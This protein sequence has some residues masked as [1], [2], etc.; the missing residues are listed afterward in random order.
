MILE[1]YLRA[2]TPEECIGYLAE[3]GGEARLLAGGTDLIPRMAQGRLSVRALIDLA[4]IPELNRIESGDGGVLIGAMRRL[5][6]VQKEGLLSGPLDV[7]RQCAG[8][9]SSM[10][11]RNA[12]T[13]GG[14]VCNASPAADT[15]PGLLVL[16]AVA[17]TYGRQGPGE[18]PLE[19]FFT[20]P[21][22]TVLQPGELLIG[23]RIPH[24][25]LHTGAAYRKYAIR[26]DSDIS[27]VGAGA[28]LTLDKQGRIAEARIAL[29]SAGPAP[30]RM[31]GEEKMLAGLLPEA[32]AFKEAAESCAENCS[33][34]TD[35]RA[36]KEYRKEMIRLWVEDALQAAWKAIAVQP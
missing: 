8:H 25:P 10:Q 17:L 5:G 23:L 3:Y 11:I 35:H 16:D 9:V 14:N 22:R 27:I 24:P 20:G 15:V 26:G 32:K 6:A 4:R 7:L 29:A 30:L 19:S 34:V 28:R 31:K 18:T 33:P 12:A 13:L 21:G 36:T 2:D 1:R